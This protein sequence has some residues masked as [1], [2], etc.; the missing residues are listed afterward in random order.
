[1]D[2]INMRIIKLKNGKVKAQYYIIQYFS[3]NKKRK[4]ARYSEEFE[5]EEDA[6]NQIESLHLS[7][8]YLTTSSEEEAKTTRLLTV[9]Y[10]DTDLF[11]KQ[12]RNYGEEIYYRMK[13]SVFTPNARASCSKQKTL[14]TPWLSSKQECLDYANEIKR[15][16]GVK[17]RKLRI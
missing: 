17:S 12:Y 13:F 5:N 2:R 9:Y 8:E 1:M 4:I 7:E 6:I 14:E 11:R 15:K 16:A 10:S 3:D